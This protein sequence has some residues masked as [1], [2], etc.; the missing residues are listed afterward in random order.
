MDIKTTTRRAVCSLSLILGLTAQAANADLYPFASDRSQILDAIATDGSARVLVLAASLETKGLH[1][2][3]GTQAITNAI[4]AFSS[5][6]LTVIRESSQKLGKYGFLHLEVDEAALTTLENSG[7]AY[8]VEYDRPF[9]LNGVGDVIEV[10]IDQPR[11]SM[12]GTYPWLGTGQA[13]A[14]V[15]TG[16]QSDHE[17]FDP[18]LIESEL[19]RGDYRG[20]WNFGVVDQTCFSVPDSGL[21][22]F[23][24][25][26]VCSTPPTAEE[27]EPNPTEPLAD[28]GTAVASVAAGLIGQA[29][30]AGIISVRVGVKETSVSACAKKGVPA[31]CEV[32]T[33]Q[34]I[35]SAL[36]DLYDRYIV[37]EDSLPNGVPSLSVV[38]L[39]LGS[40]MTLKD[41][42]D[43]SEVN[44]AMGSAIS[45]LTSAGITV[46]A[47][48]GNDGVRDDSTVNFPACLP[49][50]ISVG[51]LS[52]TYTNFAGWIRTPH[53]T[54]NLGNTVDYVFKGTDVPGALFGAAGATNLY[55][56]FTGTSFSSPAI[57]GLIANM[58]AVKGGRPVTPKQARNLLTY[59]GDSMDFSAYVEPSVKSDYVRPYPE[60]AVDAAKYL[61][62]TGSVSSRVIEA[63][64]KDALKIPLNVNTG[65]GQ[66]RI[67]WGDGN[68]E[69]RILDGNEDY[70]TH[71]YKQQG[72]YSLKII[73]YDEELTE[74]AN[75]SAVSLALSAQT[76]FSIQVYGSVAQSAP[77]FLF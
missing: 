75:E 24:Q 50:V 49:D 55:D 71:S 12:A 22:G 44:S 62:N 4:N 59:T 20:I 68:I 43:T 57:A 64:F 51:N 2:T 46:V 29:P 40:K 72:S 19:M 25:S 70:L 35:T 47:G 48:A 32:L 52:E 58:S 13:I 54:T 9:S 3:S 42:T 28:H 6:G 60:L 31:P 7:L 63:S 65:L 11:I 37:N 74:T 39:S 61:G 15:D 27:L 34:S 26:S 36:E 18:D 45:R 41:C 10:D 8:L 73:S 33:S 17:Y 21:S 53:E 1:H 23:S 66:V 5:A 76:P 56:K 77:T 14:I 16:V 69:T 30:G 38:N 67:D